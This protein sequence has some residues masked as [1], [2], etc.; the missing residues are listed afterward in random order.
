V[1]VYSLL[2][3]K[4]REFGQ[5]VLA[6]NDEEIRRIVLDSVPGSNTVMSKHPEDFDVFCVGEF[7]ENSGRLTVAD[8]KLV[9]NVGQLLEVLVNANS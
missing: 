8:A 2:D 1:K 9:V 7:D 3:R 6:R 4:V 5:L